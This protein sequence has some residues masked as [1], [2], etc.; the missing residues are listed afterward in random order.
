MG[1]LVLEPE[2]DNKSGT[3]GVWQTLQQPEPRT[4]GVV[5]IFGARITAGTN[6]RAEVWISWAV[7]SV[8]LDRV[9]RSDPWDGLGCGR[10]EQ[11]SPEIY[12]NK[13]VI[14]SFCS[15]GEE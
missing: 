14:I 5:G 13:V 3:L 9:I 6:P 10:T 8:M 1:S 11:V 2:L 7:I 4:G 15:S 12:I